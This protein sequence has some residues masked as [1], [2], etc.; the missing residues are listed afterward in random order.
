[1]KLHDNNRQK[2]E[3]NATEISLRTSFGYIFLPPSEKIQINVKH[4]HT[5]SKVALKAFVL[6]LT[7]INFT[8]RT[9]NLLAVEKN[10]LEDASAAT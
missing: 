5:E 4:C 7:T 3:C 9:E 8:Q 6:V 10:G 1:M 2:P